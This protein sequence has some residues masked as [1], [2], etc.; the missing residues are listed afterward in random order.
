[1][2]PM[3]AILDRYVYRE[4]AAPF[5]IGVGVFT[6]FL[7]IDRIYQ[8][9]DLVITKS[10]PFHLVLSLLV[11]MLPAFLTL[12]FPMALLVAVLLACGRLAGDLEVAALQASGVSPLR[13][14][15]PFLVVALLVSLASAALTLAVTPWATAAFQHQLFKILQ[16]RAASGIK[17]RVF[18]GSFGQLVVYVEEMSASQVALKGLV[19]SDERDPK[20]SR[21]IAAREGRLLTDEENRRITLR[22]IDGALSETD[23]GNPRRFRHTAFT[24]Y[25]MNLAM[26]S[27]L[28]AGARAEKPERDLSLPALLQRT[29][30]LERA[31]QPAAPYQVELHKRFAL[32]L[33]SLVFVLV[34][35]P[36]GTRSHRG[37]RGVALAITLAIVLSYY[38]VFTS[39]EGLALRGHLPAWGAIWLPNAV[40]GLVGAA[41][42]RVTTMGLP[43]RWTLPLWRLREAVARRRPAPAAAALASARPA[44]RLRGPRNSS[45]IIDRY[46]LREYLMFLAIGLGVG[47]VLFV[48]VDLLQTLDR[49]LR[50][51]PPLVYIVQ[52]F[53]YRLPGALYEGLP[54][55]VLLATV[56]LFL[57]LTRQRELDALKAAGVSLYRTSLPI[58]LMAL[59][60]SAGA[61]LF[62]ETLLPDLNGKAEEVDQVRIR[63]NLPR[64]LQRQA[65][66]WYRSS[67]TRFFRMDLVD[68]VDQSVSGLLL[69]DL[70][71][72]FRLTTRL[73]AA[74][75]QWTAEGWRLSN[76]VLREFGPGNQ[77]RSA[78]FTSRSLDIPEQISDFIRVNRPPE[79][80]S[81]LELR[82]YVQ[83]LQESGHQVGKYVVHL[84]SKLSF[85][86]IH[87]IMALVAIPFA[88]VSPR[89][90][91]RA[92]GIG[93]AIV[94]A[95]GYWVVHSMAISFAKVDLLPPMLA[96][97]T[98]NIVFAGLGAALF[99]RART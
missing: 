42:L 69:L 52:H 71:R 54:I 57:S 27:R 44:P 14:L 37:G 74:K 1:M 98:A 38:V 95:V 35:F 77:V 80:M 83:K 78:P 99:L 88:L 15:R 40:F 16:T 60:I 81:F 7:V 91:G 65:Q 93:I 72:G 46:L 73:D 5:F 82:T 3:L 30:E 23:T 48:V 49:F 76:G 32:P 86:L 20:L 97:W 43:A 8:L 96:A 6:F 21:I 26:D 70:D 41:L 45:F 25:D 4:V 87:V 68:P 63:G 84:Y 89:S 53:V 51:K 94:I 59:L 2:Q 17:E 12:T 47:A 85:P 24:L 64:H 67:D 66:L 39:L 79:A 36:L 55:I 62:Q 50:I 13:L 90:G 58:L 18:N 9:T 34:G 22:F 56:F 61:M 29:R 28:A 31:D 75:A 92:V 10:V 33:A 11:F 19:V